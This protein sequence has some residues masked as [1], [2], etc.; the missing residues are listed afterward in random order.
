MLDTKLEKK[1]KTFLFGTSKK[2]ENL[3]I[4]IIFFSILIELIN[5]V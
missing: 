3:A 4:K 2:T 1:I 5:M